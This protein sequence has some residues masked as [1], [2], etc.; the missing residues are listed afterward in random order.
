MVLKLHHT[1]LDDAAIDGLSGRE[2][3]ALTQECPL[4]VRRQVRLIPALQNEAA[5]SRPGERRSPLFGPQELRGDGEDLGPEMP[6]GAFQSQ[7]V[8][9]CEG[10]RCR[11]VDDED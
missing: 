1:D 6:V 9:K 2:F 5:R 7:R 4:D 11:Q 8:W 3:G 10:A